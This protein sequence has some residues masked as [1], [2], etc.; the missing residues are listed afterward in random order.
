MN[1]EHEGRNTFCIVETLFQTFRDCH[2]SDYYKNSISI[3]KH[4]NKSILFQIFCL[5][6]TFKS[7]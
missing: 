2:N 7:S 6:K 4:M 3:K 5:K 1:F